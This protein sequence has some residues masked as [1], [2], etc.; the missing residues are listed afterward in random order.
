MELVLK[1]EWS[2]PVHVVD[3][4]PNIVMTLFLVFPGRGW[5]NLDGRK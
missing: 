3:A 1:G 5:W 4:P 2:L